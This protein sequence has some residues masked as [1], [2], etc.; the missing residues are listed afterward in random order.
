MVFLTYKGEIYIPDLIIGIK[1]KK[2]IAIAYWNVFGH[3]FLYGYPCIVEGF[4]KKLV[5]TLL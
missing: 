2:K 3:G 4:R 1:I 5:D